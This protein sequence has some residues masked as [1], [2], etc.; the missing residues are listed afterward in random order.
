[1]FIRGLLAGGAVRVLIVEAHAPADEARRRHALSPTAAKLTAQSMVAAALL[2]AHLK[3]EEQLTVQIQGSRPRLGIYVDHTADGAIRART[4]PAHLS[5]AAF[6]AEGHLEGA[7][8]AVKYVGDKEVYRGITEIDGS[9]EAALTRHLGDSAQ[10]TAVLRMHADVS[11]DGRVVAA[12]GMLVERLP[13]EAG[14]PTIDV[15]AFSA[16]YA[17]VADVEA[18]VLMTE[19]AFGKVLGEPI[20]ILESSPL[21]WQCRCS[22]DKVRGTLAALGVDELDDMITRDGGAEVTCHFCN[23]VYQLDRRALSDLR[24]AAARPDG[25]DLP[26]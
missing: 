26:S 11:S 6:V 23:E 22:L 25:D 14:Q 2:S 7:M 19:V 15:A 3:G 24:D 9:I 1:M 8:L 21:R 13:H 16:Q 4:T 12:A 5:P 17:A 18:D 10:V 20:D